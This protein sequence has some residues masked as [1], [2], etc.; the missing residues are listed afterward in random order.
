MVSSA[1]RHFT[2]GGPGC[3][4]WNVDGENIAVACEPMEFS[5]PLLVVVSPTRPTTSV[6][7]SVDDEA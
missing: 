3:T 5:H 7:L 2:H 6:I 4:T 1:V